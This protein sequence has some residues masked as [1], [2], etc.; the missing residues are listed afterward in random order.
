MESKMRKTS[1][2]LTATRS[3][4]DYKPITAKKTRESSLEDLHPRVRT[5]VNSVADEWGVDPEKLLDVAGQQ[6]QLNMQDWETR[7][8]VKK[9]ARKTLGIN[10]RTTTNMENRRSKKHGE[11]FANKSGVDQVVTEAQSL[12]PGFNWGQDPARAL[13]EAVNEG[14]KPQPK[15]HDKNNLDSAASYLQ[16][17]YGEL[18]A[19][20]F[21]ARN[22]TDVDIYSLSPADL[23]RYAGWDPDQHP[24]NE[25]GEFSHK[26]SYAELVRSVNHPKLP[27]FKPGKETA[28]LI[29][30]V[31]YENGISARDA[32][33]ELLND[34]DGVLE[35]IFPT[36]Y[37]KSVNQY[38]DAVQKTMDS[39]HGSQDY[40][41][42]ITGCDPAWYGS[43][44][45]CAY[46]V[47]SELAQKA[48]EPL[49]ATALKKWMEDPKN[50]A[51]VKKKA[52]SM[53]SRD[54]YG[55]PADLDRYAA[56]ITDTTKE[57][58]RLI[59]E[60][61]T[62]IYGLDVDPDEPDQYAWLNWD[63]NEHPR[64][65]R[66][67]FAKKAEM[68][69]DVSAKV[70]EALKGKRTKTSA[71]ELAGMLANLSVKE[72]HALKKTHGISASGVKSDLITKIA[73]RLD[74][75]RRAD[76][77]AEPVIARTRLT[78][79]QIKNAASDTAR[80]MSRDNIL[81]QINFIN[82]QLANNP[83]HTM[84]DELYI[85][86]TALGTKIES[87][88]TQTRMTDNQINKAA[89]SLAT[90]VSVSELQAQIDYYNKPGVIKNA[91]QLDDLYVYLAAVRMAKRKQ[92]AAKQVTGVD[93]S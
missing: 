55:S 41:D 22:W 60:I 52:D 20:P 3:N 62:A 51:L 40:S 54:D 87:N 79:K 68:L 67:R 64:D 61:L 59:A 75:G 35:H 5:A 19:A 93:V 28:Q 25:S 49:M 39:L 30:E 4:S 16:R 84:M 14:A 81:A 32:V 80:K 15:L 31:M 63:E 10:Q 65:R 58:A 37:W 18:E 50:M 78:D 8:A 82:G 26:V 9:H 72:L 45:G 70:G 21:H 27:E 69:A 73:N 91:A 89:K 13:M 85:H 46:D 77:S 44:T 71:N 6:H 1:A 57:K 17:T 76:M 36:Q 24:R 12:Y 7:E 92:N 47:A 42:T 33:S 56:E 11:D 53:N 86:Q 29:A 83:T 66:G 48:R 43:D 90:R 38:E 23:D 88:A 74:S 2:D 34:E